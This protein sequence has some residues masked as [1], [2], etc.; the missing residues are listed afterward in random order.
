MS[1][2]EG[3]FEKVKAELA[4]DHA[5]GD[6]IDVGAPLVVIGNLLRPVGIDNYGRVWV[7]KGKELVMV[8]D[9][10]ANL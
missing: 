1:F 6:K 10:S 9:F 4:E 7:Q 2:V 5:I 8:A 3:L